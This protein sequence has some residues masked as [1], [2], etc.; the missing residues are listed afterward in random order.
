M[1]GKKIITSI[2]LSISILLVVFA[3]GKNEEKTDENAIIISETDTE[4]LFG[5][6]YREA[7]KWSHTY[8]PT[9]DAE[10]I[11]KKEAIKWM[12]L[13]KDEKKKEMTLI[14]KFAIDIY[15]VD[16]TKL[17]KDLNWS[18]S[19]L[20]EYINDNLFNEMF[21][22]KD[23]K[24]IVK[25]VIKDKSLNNIKSEIESSD[26]MFLLSA[27]EVKKYNV[28]KTVATNYASDKGSIYYSTNCTWWLRTSA[29]LS[30]RLCFVDINGNVN[31][32]GAKENAKNMIRPTIKVK[33]NYKK[34]VEKNNDETINVVKDIEGGVP[35]GLAGYEI[36]LGKYR[37][38]DNEN[39]SIKWIVLD[40]DENDH[41]ALIISKYGLE[42]MHF[43]KMGK[44]TSTWDKSELRKWLN[45]DF[46][47]TAFT[48]DDE[49]YILDT[50][51]V[52]EDNM[53]TGTYDGKDT[54]DKVFLLSLSEAKKYFANMKTICLPAFVNDKANQRDGASP[55]VSWWLRTPGDKSGKICTSY[56]YDNRNKFDSN[57]KFATSVSAVRPCMWI[58]Y[59]DKELVSENDGKSR[60][61]I[62][63][64]NS[65]V[66]FGKYYTLNYDYIIE[67]LDWKVLYKDEENKKALL[68]SS[69]AIDNIPYNDKY[70]IVTWENSY[71]REWLN[72]D[73]YNFAFNTQDKKKIVKTKLSNYNYFSSEDGGND[74]E[75]YVFL[76]SA[77]EAL[78]YLDEDMRCEIT[79][80]AI[81]KKGAH[82]G[83]GVSDDGKNTYYKYANYALRTPADNGYTTKSIHSV[84]Y[85][86]DGAEEPIKGASIRPAI[87]VNYRD[88]A[89]DRSDIDEINI[90]DNQKNIDFVSNN[91][92]LMNNT[93]SHLYSDGMMI[94]KDDKIV[95]MGRYP[96]IRKI[97]DEKLEK[98]KSDPS[99]SFTLEYIEIE[100]DIKWIVLDYDE[101]EGKA[102]L[103]SEKI[104]DGNPDSESGLSVKWSESKLRK[105]LNGEFFDKAFNSEEKNNI[106]MT[107]L[108]TKIV[109]YNDE[110]EETEDKIFAISD[111]EIHHYYPDMKSRIAKMTSYAASKV[112]YADGEKNTGSYW[113]RGID[114][115]V[116][117]YNGKTYYEFMKRDVTGVRPAMWVKVNKDL[118]NIMYKNFITYERYESLINAM[119]S[120]D[121]DNY[122]NFPV[123]NKFKVENEGGLFK[124]YELNADDNYTYCIFVD[125]DTQAIKIYEYYDEYEGGYYKSTYN[126][127]EIDLVYT[128]DQYK[129]IDEITTVK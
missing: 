64:V 52:S 8:N 92:A 22:E 84:G 11:L 50:N 114:E 39:E 46:L 35:V 66:G 31:Y 30:D 100:D 129:F 28:E 105:F 103:F 44:L 117:G 71:A 126:T 122:D 112:P 81:D 67:K 53:E 42:N 110:N 34:D 51:V 106:L 63:D 40:K 74:T 13:D 86:I 108:E 9:E 102:L 82:F 104:L 125:K 96:Q 75:D 127:R 21:D 128:M 95:E 23:K 99:K 101:K 27:D 17:Q 91:K 37:F 56:H 115:Y 3:C 72:N 26:N 25:T 45:S 47:R 76:L 20:R 60:L 73:F 89:E 83:C 93:T 29:I 65:H 24:S 123:T 121:V 90:D 10:S 58:K 78:Y 109:S 5:N 18:N 59:V 120:K 107:K 116:D 19:N 48:I 87:W 68:L 6:F 32:E 118:D 79:P 43:D 36:E 62:G 113:I 88:G 98:F 77:D 38:L 119:F 94:S 49:K 97:D 41:K 1:N 69:Y 4:I 55:Y 54:I 15:Q 124:R 80:Y 7:D 16:E 12:I 61:I 111:E 70:D 57:G 33:F 14:T 85:M 2:V